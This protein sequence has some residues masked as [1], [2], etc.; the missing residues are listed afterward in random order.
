MCTTIS[1][2]AQ[3]TSGWVHYWRPPPS[4]YQSVG[5]APWTYDCGRQGAQTQ[6]DSSHRVH[7]M[8]G[9]LRSIKEVG[10]SIYPG[11]DVA[12]G[13]GAERVRP[14]PWGF[15]APRAEGPRGPKLR[16]KQLKPSQKSRNLCGNRQQ[17]TS[18][19]SGPLWPPGPTRKHRAPV[20]IR[21]SSTRILTPNS[22]LHG[23]SPLFFSDG[24][25]F[26]FEKKKF[27]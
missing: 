3:W 9:Q 26:T 25:K 10:I 16:R 23:F 6:Y 7:Q 13:G 19:Q 12:K 21:G 24:P 27:F 15:W 4:W 20:T 17:S 11:R 14:P 1:Q 18:G 2:A 8:T 5:G 22:K